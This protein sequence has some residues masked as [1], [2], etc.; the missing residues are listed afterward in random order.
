MVQRPIEDKIGI[1][2][3]KGEPSKGYEV[4]EEKDLVNQQHNQ[5]EDLNKEVANQKWF[6]AS[7]LRHGLLLQKGSYFSQS[8]NGFT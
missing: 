8:I 3:I 1:G 5:Q 4:T 6:G 2:D 7:P